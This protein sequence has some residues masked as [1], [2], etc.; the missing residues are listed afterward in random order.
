MSVLTIRG[1]DPESAKILKKKAEQEGL[2]VNGFL[3]K[4]IRQTLGT[5]KR[6]GQI[7]DDLDRLAGTWTEKEF[8]EFKKNTAAFEKIDEKQWR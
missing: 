6:R 5:D 3:L 8:R 4:A 2:S 1:L 7:Y